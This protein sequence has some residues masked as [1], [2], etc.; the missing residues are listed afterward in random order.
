MTR[1]LTDLLPSVES[2]WLVPPMLMCIRESRLLTLKVALPLP[3]HFRL[4][5][6]QKRRRSARWFF[7][8]WPPSSITAGTS[9]IN[10]PTGSLAYPSNSRVGVSSHHAINELAKVLFSQNNL[11]LCEDIYESYNDRIQ[12]E[13]TQCSSGQLVVPLLFL[14]Q[15]HLLLLLRSRSTLR[16]QLQAGERATSS[17]SPDV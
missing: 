1:I 4:E 2:N 10:E 11:R 9:S 3:F 13:L 16:R 5:K 17:G 12:Q 14:T 7:A 15:V 6:S 8:T